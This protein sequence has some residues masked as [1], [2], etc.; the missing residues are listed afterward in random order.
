MIVEMITNRSLFQLKENKSIAEIVFKNE[1][2][3]IKIFRSPYF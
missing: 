2:L 1:G 3:L